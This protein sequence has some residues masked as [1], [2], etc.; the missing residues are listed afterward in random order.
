MKH[1]GASKKD[2]LL[3]CFGFKAVLCGSMLVYPWV[4][5]RWSASSVAVLI[6]CVVFLD[7][8][9]QAWANYLLTNDI[10]FP[11]MSWSIV[12]HQSNGLVHQLVY[13]RSMNQL[14][15]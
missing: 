7:G 8:S 9:G 15:H 13:T 12:A 6:G 11:F 4:V 14:N 3:L 2:W 1:C 10:F 5:S